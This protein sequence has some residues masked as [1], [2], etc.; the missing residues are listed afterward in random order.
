MAAW[1]LDELRKALE[2]HGWRILEQVDGDERRTAAAWRIQR[3]TRIDPLFLDFDAMGLNFEDVTIV[4]PLDKAY[5]ASV[6]GVPLLGVYF[7]KK[8]S[9]AMWHNELAK[10][11]EGLDALEATS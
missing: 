9:R 5:G 11:L 6:R 8:S 1:H 2:N 7:Y 3:S 4:L 10:L